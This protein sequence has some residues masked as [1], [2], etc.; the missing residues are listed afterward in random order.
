MRPRHDA[1]SGSIDL[2]SWLSP[3]SSSWPSV[4][5]CSGSPVD[6]R[7]ADRLEG[8]TR[9]LR[10][11]GRLL[12]H[13]PSPS[14][15]PNGPIQ[16]RAD[17]QMIIGDRNPPPATALWC[18]TDSFVA[19]AVGAARARATEQLLSHGGWGPVSKK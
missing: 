7:Y 17:A 2:P 3:R 15:C 6:P 8:V 5:C 12:R 13:G 14:T 1:S 9:Q 4:N 10:R 18:R 19:G 11:Q 16:D